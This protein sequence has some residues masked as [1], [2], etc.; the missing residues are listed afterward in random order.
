MKEL[1]GHHVNFLYLV[2]KLAHDSGYPWDEAE[3][4]TRH[5][6]HSPDGDKLQDRGDAS[7]ACEDM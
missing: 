1:E 6:S 3:D 5:L 7:L 4:F 2:K